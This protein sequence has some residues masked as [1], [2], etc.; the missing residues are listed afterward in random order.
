MRAEKSQGGTTGE[1][2]EG[3]VSEREEK[4][5]ERA[6]SQGEV[7]LEGESLK[8]RKGERSEG[9]RDERGP[10]VDHHLPHPS[11]CMQLYQSVAPNS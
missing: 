5:R 9:K 11:A 1:E 4:G 6:A 8:K 7:T 3:N 10:P 2:E